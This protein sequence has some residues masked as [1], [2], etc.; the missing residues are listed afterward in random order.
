ML[1]RLSGRHVGGH[2]GVIRLRAGQGCGKEKREKKCDSI[3]GFGRKW[4]VMI[5]RRHIPLAYYAD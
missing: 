4:T 3:H 1:V 2:H 5:G